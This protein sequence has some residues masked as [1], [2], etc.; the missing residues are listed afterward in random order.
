MCIISDVRRSGREIAE[1]IEKIKR[2]TPLPSIRPI[3]CF[4]TAESRQ[5]RRIYF[6]GRSEPET[7]T[8]SPNNFLL[9]ACT[10]YPA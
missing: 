7:L 5:G 10:Y 9:N 6:K 4:L 1:K 2:R 3:K 8:L